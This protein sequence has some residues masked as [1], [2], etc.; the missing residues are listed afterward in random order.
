[1]VQSEYSVGETDR[2]AEVC[3][4]LNELQNEQL[5]INVIVELTAASVTASTLTVPLPADDGFC[6]PEDAVA[7]YETV[8]TLQVE[9]SSTSRVGA[10][11]C[12]RQQITV[13]DDTIVEDPETF[14]VSIIDSL[15]PGIDVDPAANSTTVSIISDARDRKSNVSWSINY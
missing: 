3:L 6:N 14:M 4:R 10:I 7:D 15:P 13:N 1:M 11:S 12:T 5:E 8:Q 2:N 9:F